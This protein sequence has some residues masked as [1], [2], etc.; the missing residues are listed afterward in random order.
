NIDDQTRVEQL[1]AAQR[2]AIAAKSGIWS[3]RHSPEEYY[4]AKKGSF[5]FHRPICHSLQKTDYNE[6]VRF[7]TREEA[8][9]L[10]YSPCRNCHP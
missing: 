8:S 10:G 1:L 7:S 4:L 3:I 5:R 2:E 9:Q 6:L